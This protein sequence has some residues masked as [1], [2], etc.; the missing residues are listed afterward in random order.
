VSGCV[1][2]IEDAR[3]QFGDKDNLLLFFTHNEKADEAKKSLY[4]SLIGKGWTKDEIYAMVGVGAAGSSPG[5]RG[6]LSKVI[7]APPR[8]AAA[9]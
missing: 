5:A 6:N 9:P 3:R 1:Q 4:L 2:R 8:A 7:P